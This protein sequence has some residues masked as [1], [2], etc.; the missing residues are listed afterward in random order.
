MKYAL[1]IPGVVD[2]ERH[3]EAFCLLVPL[4]RRVGPHQ[5]LVAHHQAGMKDLIASFS[6]HLIRHWR[7]AVGHHHYYFAAE[8]LLIELERRLALAVESQ[9]GVHLHGA[10]RWLGLVWLLFLRQ[11]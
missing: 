6:R 7:A 8:T 1:G 3:G 2:A 11:L 10:L 4:G 9:I 5:Y